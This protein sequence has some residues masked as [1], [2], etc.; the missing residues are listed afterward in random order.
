MDSGENLIK[1]GKR[2]HVSPFKILALNPKFSD[3]QD[4]KA[5]DII[6][7][8]S[9]YAKRCQIYIHADNYLPYQISVFDELGL[10]EQYIFT[11]INLSDYP[12]QQ[13][14]ISFEYTRNIQ[15]E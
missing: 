9:A 7:I 5:G 4:V 6:R 14:I 12:G 3:Y 1:L 8:P 10:F 13:L 15:K 2:L 11:D